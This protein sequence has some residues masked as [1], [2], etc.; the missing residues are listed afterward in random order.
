M[1]IRRGVIGAVV[2][3]VLTVGLSSTAIAMDEEVRT[4]SVAR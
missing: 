1:K 4:T 2:A 3:I